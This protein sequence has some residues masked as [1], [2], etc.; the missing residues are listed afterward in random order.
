MLAHIVKLITRI[1]PLKCLL[2]K[3]TLTGKLA[4]WVVILSEFDIHY[5]DRKAIK[6]QVI[7]DQLAEAPLQEGNPMHIEFPNLDIFTTTTKQSWT[8]YFDGSYTQ[9]GSRAR[10]LFVTPK[11]HTI[12]KSY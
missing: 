4:K 7:A 9:H 5:I 11:G 6:E 1:D 12:R 3:A 8:L 10:I 2:R